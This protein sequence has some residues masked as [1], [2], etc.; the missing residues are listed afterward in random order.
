MGAFEDWLKERFTRW[1]ETRDNF[2]DA[3]ALMSQMFEE[4]SSLAVNANDAVDILKRTGER[5]DRQM[6]ADYTAF[7]EELLSA[8]KY[9]RSISLKSLGLAL[10]GVF[11][12]GL[13]VGLLL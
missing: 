3:I 7:K 9:S 12:S 4:W 1:E 2:Q 13:V 8:I 10:L 11:L 5:W 6:F